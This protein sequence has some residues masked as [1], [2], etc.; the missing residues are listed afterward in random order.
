MF[1]FARIVLDTVRD[2]ISIKEIRDQLRCPPK[3]L[4][5]A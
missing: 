1:L 2:L 4:R 5:E 3:N